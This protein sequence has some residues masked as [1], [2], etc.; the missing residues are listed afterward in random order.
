MT[1]IKRDAFSN[2][3]DFWVTLN[4]FMA[5]CRIVQPPNFERGL[6]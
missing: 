1:A 6:F 3:E 5:Y 2:I 4:D